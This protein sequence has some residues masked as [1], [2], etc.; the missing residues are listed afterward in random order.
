MKC[1]F[2]LTGVDVSLKIESFHRKHFKVGE[3]DGGTVHI[4][5]Q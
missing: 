4:R 1:S 2:I 5:F 3:W